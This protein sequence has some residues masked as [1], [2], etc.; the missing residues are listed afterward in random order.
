MDM[1][2]DPGKPHPTETPGWKSSEFVVTVL[3]V[4]FAGVAM[5][6]QVHQGKQIDLGPILAA[7]V[8]S[9]AFSMARGYTKANAPQ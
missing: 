5:L 7:A 6:L 4:V 8:S 1:V 2:V 9:G 3:V